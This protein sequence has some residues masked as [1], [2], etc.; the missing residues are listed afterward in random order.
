MD[1]NKLKKAYEFL[2]LAWQE[3]EEYK[4]NGREVVLQEACEKSWDAVVQVLKAVNPKIRR[5]A[6]FGK[7]AAKLA[8][9][10][11]NEHIVYGEACGETLHRSGFYD[12]ALDIVAVKHQLKCVNNF[13]K[14]IDNI[15]KGKKQSKS[16]IFLTFTGWKPV[17]LCVTKRIG[18]FFSGNRLS[19]ISIPI[20]Q[21]PITN[22]PVTQFSYQL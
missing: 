20:I 7:T 2:D 19:V 16:C 21:L 11:N 10:H 4:K 5:H 22:Y 9:E 14:L 3:L 18:M 1:N 8:E 12:S 13:L 17:L 15:L 6:D